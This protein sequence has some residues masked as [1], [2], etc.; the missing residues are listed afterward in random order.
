MWRHVGNVPPHSV[1]PSKMKDG[2]KREG[3]TVASR[4]RSPAAAHLLQPHGKWLAG[5]PEYEAVEAGRG[6]PMSWTSS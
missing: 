4:K 5:L 2:P 6:R 3:R 1:R